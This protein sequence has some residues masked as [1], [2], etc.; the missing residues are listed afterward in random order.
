[1]GV[2][3][4]RAG[5]A[6]PRE[7]ATAPKPSTA[8]PLVLLGG[9]A[10][11]V[12]VVAGLRA[13]S[14]LVAPTFLALVMT[15]TAHPIRGWFE[16]HGMPALVGSL[17]ALLAVYAALVALTTSLVVAGAQFAQLIPGY[18]DDL[19]TLVT[20]ALTALEDL[21]VDSEQVDEMAAGIDV[22][23]LVSF[24]RDVLVDLAGVLGDL[25]FLVT[26]VLFMVFD[27]ARFARHLEA[28]P[29]T[30]RTL[31]QGLSRFARATRTYVLVSTVF[32]LIVAV[33]DVLALLWIGVPGVLLW[34][35]LSFV[36][37][38]IPNIGFVI[39]VI[40]PAVV[41]T[42][43]SG[44]SGL[45][46]VLAAYSVINVVIQTI[47]QPRVVGDAVGLSPTVTMLSLVFWA[48]A[49]GA[50]GAL[51]AVPLSLFVR[52]ILLDADPRLAWV[53][54]LVSGRSPDEDSASDGSSLEEVVPGEAV[55]EG[56]R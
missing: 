56:R 41:A 11:A 17:A 8:R 22:G 30:G 5:A 28:L 32:G 4:A 38:Y 37:N 18:Q 39:G 36:T 24:A 12:V 44:W 48:W 6:S 1:L 45:V 46:A 52:G 20:D 42:L 34:G 7:E 15:V 29:G 21:G 9:L 23:G 47:I 25:F 40:P 51:L 26:L 3:I 19:D 35:L 33:F 55:A 54:P 43:E 13:A 14:D 50:L 49:L 2:D 10:A 27:A 31:V 53:L 16:R